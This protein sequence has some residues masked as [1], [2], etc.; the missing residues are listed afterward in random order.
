MCVSVCVGGL[1]CRGR[2]LWACVCGV[3]QEYEYVYICVAARTLRAMQ[4]PVPCYLLSLPYAPIRI[5]ICSVVYNI[6]IAC[7][8]LLVAL[9]L[10]VLGNESLSVCL[11][12]TLLRLG[13]WE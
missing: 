13:G 9:A 12:R 8:L 4:G 1:T 2:D 7:I 6:N 3:V 11:F 10:L 5:R